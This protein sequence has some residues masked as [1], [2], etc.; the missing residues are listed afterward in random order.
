[1]L[2]FGFHNRFPVSCRLT[3]SEE[4]RHRSS[5][6]LVRT[7]ETLTCQRKEGLR[8]KVLHTVLTELSRIQITMMRWLLL[9]VKQRKISRNRCLA[10][11]VPP[12]LGTGMHLCFW[13]VANKSAFFEH[14]YGVIRIRSPKSFNT[15]E[16]RVDFFKF[17]QGPE[18]S[19]Q[20]CFVDAASEK[21]P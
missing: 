19:I 21:L 9:K 15:S 18:M 17:S 8:D 5:H 20:Q 16:T 6:P 14:S 3:H 11:P 10:I 7:N 1:M 12:K 13:S 2:R 4:V